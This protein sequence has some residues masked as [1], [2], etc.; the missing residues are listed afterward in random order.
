MTAQATL[1]P[2]GKRET[3]TTRGPIALLVAPFIARLVS[4]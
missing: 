1:C 2:S 4:D 3:R